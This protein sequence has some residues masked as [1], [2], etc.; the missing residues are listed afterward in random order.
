MPR[1]LSCAALLWAAAALAGCSD[2]V[3]RTRVEVSIDAEKSLR[4]RIRE[5]DVEVWSGLL[6]ENAWE[7]VL[8][9]Q[10]LPRGATGW[11]LSFTLPRPKLEE[12]SGY[13]ITA[14]AQDANG[15]TL[16]V[17]R[18]ISAYVSEKTIELKLEFDAAC[19]MR[20]MPCPAT[21]TCQDGQCMSS[22]VPPGEQPGA[23]PSEMPAA[24]S[25][26]A[27]AA[28]APA[29]GCQAGSGCDKKPTGPASACPTR[30]DQ[31]VCQTCPAGF[32]TG[33]ADE[34]RP[35]LRALAADGGKLEPAFDPA[36]S[37]YV[38]HVPLLQE[39]VRL[40]LQLPD[41]VEATINGAALAAG[42]SWTSPNLP[43][44]DTRVAIALSAP[45]RSN[46][47]HDVVLRREGAQRA[48]LMAAEAGPGD[49]LG[50]SVAL[51]GDRLVVGA[52]FEDGGAGSRA[53]MPNESAAAS[54]AAY[55]YV[56]DGDSW[57]QKDYLKPDNPRAGAHFGLNVALDGDYLA[58]S[59]PEDSGGGAIYMFE[60]DG[61]GFRSKA[62]LRGDKDGLLLGRAVALQGQRVV[63]GAPGDSTGASGAGSVF[64]FERTGGEWK[65]D[66]TLRVGSPG[67][68]DYLGS[69][70]AL[71]GDTIA[72]GATG[73][74][75]EGS[76]FPGG[77]V[78]VFVRGDQGW[79]EQQMLRPAASEPLA[80]FG[81]SV[82]I[83]GDSIAV[84]AFQSSP[85]GS[86]CVFE[87]GSDGKFGPPQLLVPSNSRPADNFGRR[88]LIR[89]D[90]LLVGA[91]HEPS[92]N[93]GIA[94]DG[95]GMATASGAVYLFSRQRDGWRQV[96]QI[97]AQAPVANEEFGH[98]LALSGDTFVVGAPSD[99]K[100]DGTGSG[101]GAF[102]V[103]R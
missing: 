56:R 22:V 92:A 37:S 85:G 88:V 15:K 23:K 71:D 97:K 43:L 18:A 30:D 1:T 93:G 68:W 84:G 28:G 59:A 78:Y 10:L 72:S 9:R 64:V 48:Q 69:S 40:D 55:V 67:V 42:G 66:K 62:T 79:K 3:E 73:R 57:V 39:R 80:F 35:A 20:E 21:F 52:P 103:F 86:A 29:P 5:V 101:S 45:G 26:D 33:P 81:E 24:G 47:S 31:G 100:L 76:T 27:G 91:P 36:E 44:G 70:V 83:S 17:V 74:T 99:P 46:R 65:L 41:A 11:P 75:V 12:N 102:Y 49:E 14:A 16:T 19:V 77:G 82:S 58:I 7:L 32:L 94:A 38:V 6:N 34:C 54:G 98:A 4:E 51:S 96:T 87:R 8:K 13:L 2:F 50:R 95:G 90:T 61:S 63:A 25:G 53:G 60:W 89:G